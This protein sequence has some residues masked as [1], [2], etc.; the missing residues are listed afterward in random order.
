MLRARLDEATFHRTWELGRRTP[1]GEAL[2]L[3]TA[4]TASP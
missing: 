2:E 1:P 4:T 3:V